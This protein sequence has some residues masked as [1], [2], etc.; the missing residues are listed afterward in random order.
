MRRFPKRERLT[1]IA[2]GRM[3]RLERTVE[4]GRALLR[5]ANAVVEWFPARGELEIAGRG[6]D[7]LDPERLTLSLGDF[8]ALLD[9]DLAACAAAIDKRFLALHPGFVR[10]GDGY[11]C[12]AYRIA[13]REDRWA[14]TTLEGEETWVATLDEAAETIESWIAGEGATP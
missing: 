14:T 11:R 9:L 3:R 4:Q 8:L 12:G 7:I 1:V 5:G 6:D 13:R 2:D 10:D